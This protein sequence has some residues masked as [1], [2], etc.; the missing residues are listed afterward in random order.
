MVAVGTIPCTCLARSAFS[1]TNASACSFVRATYSASYVSGDRPGVTPEHGVAEK[2]NR[3]GPDAG[4]EVERGVR[5]GLAGMYGR[6][7]PRQNLRA[8]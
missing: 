6:V 5:I 3:H 7:E 1:V 8:Q 2:T 4:E